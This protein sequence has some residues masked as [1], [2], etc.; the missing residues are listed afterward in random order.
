MKTVKVLVS[1]VAVVGLMLAGFS[2]VALADNDVLKYESLTS[3][4]QITLSQ[5]IAAAQAHHT[6]GVAVSSE[7]DSKLG[8]V[9]YD[10]EVLSAGAIY[11]VDVDGVTGEILNS[12]KDND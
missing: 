4:A 9:I 6:G 11:D 2:S 12:R 8:K 1:K 7:L 5:A 10:V 3:K